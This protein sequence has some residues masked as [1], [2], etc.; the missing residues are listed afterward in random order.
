MF[1]GGILRVGIF[2]LIISTTLLAESI[3]FDYWYGRIIG[4]H[5]TTLEYNETEWD[6]SIMQFSH[7]IGDRGDFDA[8]A[9]RFLRVWPDWSASP[10]AFEPRFSGKLQLSK[11]VRIDLP[12]VDYNWSQ[13]TRTY[14][15]GRKVYDSTSA[16]VKVGLTYLQ[17]G[18]IRYDEER[19]SFLYL[20][21]P[22]LTKGQTYV[23]GTARFKG[24]D[25]SIYERSQVPFVRLGSAQNQDSDKL[26]V[27]DVT[28]H[29]GY[30]ENIV[31]GISGHYKRTT[32]NEDMSV[33]EFRISGEDFV[34]TS[35]YTR[36]DKRTGNEARFA[37]DAQY[38]LSPSAW[39]LGS[40]Q[41]R[42]D[43]F[44]Q[45][46]KRDENWPSFESG[47]EV[48]HESFGADLDLRFN[49]FSKTPK[50]EQQKILDNFSG[51]YDNQLD[52]GTWSLEATANWSVTELQSN[53]STLL[54]LNTSLVRDMNDISVAAN[55][56]YHTLPNL[57]F[58][59]GLSF[60]TQTDSVFN[61]ANPTQFQQLRSKF[62]A[63]YQSYTWNPQ[64]H[65][66][67][68]W[69]QVNDF[70]YVL[71]PQ[72][73]SGDWRVSAFVLPRTR[74]RVKPRTGVGSPEVRT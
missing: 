3:P 37:F 21:G 62:A 40:F 32:R 14:R 55:L 74:N 30:T 10:T 73:R 19:S 26:Y 56:T 67:I 11:S 61:F 17:D 23:S 31:L 54:A 34:D 49:Y 28:A 12:T 65:R 53:Y 52:A 20:E 16:D 48:M 22:F 36:S 24:R 66:D 13:W 68:S 42:H 1:A 2:T 72:L 43:A 38:L 71:G 9:N 60:R 39:F 64:L 58:E 29:R 45:T 6:R 35:V 18:G 59:A 44:V 70:D 33:L 25:K 4:G 57:H 69:D 51:H 46:H 50:V 47:Y 8:A 27:L 63:T 5:Q 15:S 7:R 41:Y